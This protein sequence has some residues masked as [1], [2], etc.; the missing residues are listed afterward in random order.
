[1]TTTVDSGRPYS[2]QF[3]PGDS[4]ALK[5]AVMAGLLYLFIL[6]ITLLGSTFKLFGKGFAET[7]FQST[8]N[9]V[10]GLM[11]G[12]LATAIVQS[13]STTTSL[14]VRLAA[15]G[16]NV[17]PLASAIPMVMGANIG[18]SVTN[19]IVSLGHISRRDE[20]QRAFTGSMLHDFFNVCAVAILLPLESYFH[21][22]EK[23][24]RV[25]QIQFSDFGGLK[26]TSFLGAITKPVAEWIIQLTGDNPYVAV[27]LAL[28]MMFVAL[29]YIVKVMKTLVL[30]R[31]EKFFQRYIFRTP[32]L[33]FLLGMAITVL[34]QSSSITTSIVVPLLGAGVLNAVQ[35]YPYLLGANVGTT[36]TAF[37]ASFVTG[38]VDAVAV[39]FAHLMF[40]VFGIAIF[41]PLKRVPIFL[42]ETLGKLTTRSKLVP[43]AYIVVVF[44][45]IPGIVIY[46]ME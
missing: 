40:N 31:V 1:M 43:I 39:A 2:S 7:I 33:S 26:F 41:W 21:M 10:L 46:L 8:S 4:V 29:R 9:P 42:A 32:V 15:S 13:S 37:L 11:I 38:S 35:I 28:I 27:V 36:I 44:F 20:F 30:A 12:M 18:T 22:I 25:L 34:V 6:S 23:S 45:V 19:I 16:P 24:A 17:L 3:K 5:L 14:I